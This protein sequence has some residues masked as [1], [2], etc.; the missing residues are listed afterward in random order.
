MCEIHTFKRIFYEIFETDLPIK[1]YQNIAL[2]KMGGNF[3]SLKWYIWKL[4]N[5]EI[6]K[7]EV[8]VEID[9]QRIWNHIAEMLKLHKVRTV[10]VTRIA[11]LSYLIIQ[12]VGVHPA[13]TKWIVQHLMDGQPS[14]HII[15]QI[16]VHGRVVHR[17]NR[18]VSSYLIVQSIQN[19][20]HFFWNQ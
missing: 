9:F 6:L 8:K 2:Y 14:E 11:R 17:P 5:F 15:V 10:V 19:Q 3:P 16:I 12:N 1:P 13:W 7:R 18:T 20:M 4:L